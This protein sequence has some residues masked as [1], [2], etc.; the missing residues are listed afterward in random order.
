MSK[1]T[2]WDPNAEHTP[3]VAGDK[4]VDP[5]ASA[6]GGETV[7]LN[8]PP[9]RQARAPRHAL[10]L[11]GLLTAAALVGAA[12]ATV[13]GSGP[14]TLTGLVNAARGAAPATVTASRPLNVAAIARAVDPAVVD[15][16]V[17][18]AFGEGTAQGTGMILTPSGLVLTNNHVVDGATTIMVHVQGQ[19]KP[20][21]TRV[22][23]VDPSQDVALLQLVGA[24]DLPT[25]RLGNSATVVL[26]QPVVAIG[27]ALGL[28]GTPTVTAG[29]V[30][31]ENRSITAVDQGVG[32]E[33]LSGLIETDA[34]LAPGDSGGPLVDAAGQVIGMDTAA[35]SG[36]QGT[37]T[38]GFAIPINRALKIVHQIEAGVASPSILL[39]AHGFLGVETMDATSGYGA[40]GV[41]MPPGALV[42]AVIP[43]T[44]AWNAGLARGDVI[45][46]FNGH[47]ITSA[48]ALADQVRQLK[49]GRQATVTWVD[50]W[51]Q[52]HTA[53]VTLATS[54]AL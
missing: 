23:G 43:G 27:N 8:A 47:A 29:T 40:G 4:T 2:D 1:P 49:P 17:T 37:P 51:G 28:G 14:K 31:A 30:T 46:A 48:T 45:T 20:Y 9:H 19:P 10:S 26:G 16:N 13:M 36:G 11:A 25:V 42:V 53:T 3:G 18:L 50:G 6:D 24:R 35:D 54:P 39:G 22:V 44:P 52:S 34:A 15:I 41:S 5:A 21:A 7:P 32:S 33:S 38:I 12:V